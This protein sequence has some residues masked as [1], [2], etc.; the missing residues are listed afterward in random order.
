[1]AM[2]LD[3]AQIR[4]REHIDR[5]YPAGAFDRSEDEFVIAGPVALA[6]DVER[7]G[8]RIRL[9]GHVRGSLELPCSRCV[10]PM[11]WPVDAAFDLLYLPMSANA[12]EGEREVDTEDLGAAFYEGDTID[13]A[14]LVREQFYLA[15]P[16]KPLCRS[17]CQGLCPECGANLN[18]APCGCDHRWVDP[19]MAALRQLLPKKSSE[20]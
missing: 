7:E 5:E 15:L 12:G 19:R 8:S 18:L 3:L 17:D 13:L 2:L 4:A 14:Q 20:H 10:E 11:A 16:M 6:F 9:V 1:M